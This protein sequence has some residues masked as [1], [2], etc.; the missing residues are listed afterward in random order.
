MKLAG[1]EATVEH[2]AG[3]RSMYFGVDFS[4]P[5]TE[6]KIKSGL[7]HLTRAGELIHSLFVQ[8]TVT[9]TA[10][11]NRSLTLR[12]VNCPYKKRCKYHINLYISMKKALSLSHT[13]TR[14]QTFD[15][16]NSYWPLKTNQALTESLNHIG[17]ISNL[18]RYLETSKGH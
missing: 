14:T 12:K 13:H 2:S 7:T 3:I 16:L 11:L 5:P 15:T 18:E 8:Q 10:V 17:I 9:R 6:L 1:D 4:L